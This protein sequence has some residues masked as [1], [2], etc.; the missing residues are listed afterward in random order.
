VGIGGIT[1]RLFFISTEVLFEPELVDDIAR[2]WV[3]LPP[4]R[5]NTVIDGVTTWKGAKERRLRYL[6]GLV[7]ERGSIV[8][9]ISCRSGASN[10]S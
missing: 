6:I 9:A 7:E 8:Q 5:G 2:E 4:A 3:I 1:V 10:E